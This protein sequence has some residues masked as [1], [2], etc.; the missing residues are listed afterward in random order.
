[1]PKTTPTR[2]P[3]T[4][5]DAEILATGVP[6]TPYALGDQ[7]ICF[8]NPGYGAEPVVLVGQPPVGSTVARIR[9]R[10]QSE[11]DVHIRYLYADTPA[12]R[13]YLAAKANAWDAL[14]TWRAAM[15]AAPAGGVEEA[16]RLSRP[17]RLAFRAADAAATALLEVAELHPY[18]VELRGAPGWPCDSKTLRL[19]RQPSGNWMDLD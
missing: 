18:P 8:D 19:Q 2:V 6:A 1:M 7:L 10:E 9:R 15:D 11:A 5:T 16:R 13:D 4:V 12:M 3:A 14:E 17:L